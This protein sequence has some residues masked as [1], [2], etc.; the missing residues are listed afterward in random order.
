MLVS[1]HKDT[2]FHNIITRLHHICNIFSAKHLHGSDFLLTFAVLNIHNIL[3]AVDNPPNSRAGFF[4]S[5][6]LVVYARP[7]LTGRGVCISHT[8]FRP[9]WSVNAPT[10]FSIQ[11]V[12]QRV[13]E[14][15]FNSR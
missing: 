4:V 11:G 1:A 13:A 14:L 10:A 12:K 3:K 6:R 2:Q 9:S 15:F 8:E 5:L 7:S